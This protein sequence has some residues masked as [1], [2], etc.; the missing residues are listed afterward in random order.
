MQNEVSIEIDRA[1]EDV[2]RLTRNHVAEWSITVVEE[3]V[4][5]EKPDGVGTTFRTV[6]ENHGK[7][8]EFQGIVTRYDPP[9]A[10]AVQMTGD[11]VDIETEVTFEDVSGRTRV[12][13]RANVTGK[14]ALGLFLFLF[15][16]MMKQSHCK[17]SA[18]E[19]ESLKRY[20]E[21]PSR[22]AAE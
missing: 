10:Y 21:D 6:T 15:G 5:D 17:A 20:C 12:T 3:E 8:M 13:Q 16:W 18:A 19:F 2:F 22:A 9:H 7:R 1:I 14:G 11:M 4:L